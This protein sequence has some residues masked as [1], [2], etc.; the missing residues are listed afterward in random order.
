MTDRPSPE[1]SPGAPRVTGWTDLVPVVLA[2]IGMAIVS[3][4]WEVVEEAFRNLG[5]GVAA[6][7]GCSLILLAEGVVLGAAFTRVSRWLAEYRQPHGSGRPVPWG[8]IA[9]VVFAGILGGAA[10]LNLEGEF[11]PWRRT[12]ELLGWLL[13]TTLAGLLYAVIARL[14]GR[15]AVA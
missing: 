15:P 5:R 1:P 10:G 9:V 14:R 2:A 11:G 13:A 7:V 4:G 3:H 6:W 8:A 12:Q